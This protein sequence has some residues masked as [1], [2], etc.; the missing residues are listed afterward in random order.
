MSKNSTTRL[1]A[2]APSVTRVLVLATLLTLVALPQGIAFGQTYEQ[3]T[4]SNGLATGFFGGVDISGSYTSGA[5][6]DTS[7]ITVRGDPNSNYCSPGTCSYTF[8]GPLNGAGYT[9]TSQMPPPVCDIEGCTPGT[10]IGPGTAT[11]HV[12][13]ANAT[14]ASLGFEDT[15]ELFSGYG[16][17][18]CVAKATPPPPPPPPP[19]GPFQVTLTGNGTPKITASY[20]PANGLNLQAAATACGFIG[21]DW[22]QLVTNA[23]CPSGMYAQV[24]GNLA[25]SNLCPGG[26]LTAGLQPS[27]VVAPPIYDIPKGGFLKFFVNGSIY[28]PYPFYYDTDTAKTPG[29]PWA[30]GKQIINDS[31]DMLMFYDGP[32]DPCLP[33]GPL[34]D[35][36]LEDLTA[37]RK[38]EC[39]GITAPVGSYLSFSTALVGILPATADYPNGAPSAPLVP[40]NWNDN[41]NGTAGGIA[42]WS[43]LNPIDTGSGVGNITITSINGVAVPPVIPPTLVS[44][45]ASG[46][47]YSRVSKTFVGTVTI[48]NIGGTTLTTPTSFQLVLN[49]LP[50]GVTLANTM[51]TFNHCP[52]VTI[53]ALVSLA[54]GQSVTVAVQFSNPSNAVIN[55]TPEFYAGSF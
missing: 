33:T 17:L 35:T 44:T 30:P 25:V 52:Y 1:E 2:G 53:P 24:P 43:S 39:G 4:I 47:A 11:L 55:F 31:G 10:T 32:T 8:T 20:T 26:S 36:Q 46:L 28:D 5:T 29:Q 13:Q 48:T 38:D 41:Y 37:T 21:F 19:C 18:S 42:A 49:S 50:A 16:T 34:T 3:C 12:Y 54:P 14:Q 51:G 6:P 9:Q 15:D 45:T 40:W 7:S 22:E 23:P 27:G